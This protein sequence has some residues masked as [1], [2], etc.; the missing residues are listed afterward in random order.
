MGSKI[1]HSSVK[2]SATGFLLIGQPRRDQRVPATHAQTITAT[3]A[4]TVIQDRKK[5]YYIVRFI[6]PLYRLLR[7]LAGQVNFDIRV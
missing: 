5:I 1:L 4:A 6:V 7:A 3:P 2:T